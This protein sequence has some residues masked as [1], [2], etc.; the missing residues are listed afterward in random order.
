VAQ[1]GHE[2]LKITDYAHPDLILLDIM[3]PGGLSGF[4]V[5]KQLKSEESTRDIPVI[6]MTALTDTVNKIK[7]FELGAADYITKTVFNKKNC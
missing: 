5:C 3:M 4:D 2:S 1:D 7:G 6:F